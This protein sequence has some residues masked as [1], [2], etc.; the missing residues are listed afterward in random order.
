MTQTESLAA[1]VAYC[2]LVCGACPAVGQC[3]GCRAGGGDVGCEVRACAQER[4]LVGCWE[5]ADFPCTRGGMGSADWRGLNIAGIQ[6]VRAHG[7]EAMSARVAERSGHPAEW[8]SYKGLSAE[9]I[10]RQWWE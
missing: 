2:G 4:Q 3:P 6:S 8:A 5:C 10:I 7:T 1:S 9:E